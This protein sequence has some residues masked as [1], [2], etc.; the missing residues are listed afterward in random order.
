MAGQP[1]AAIQ[2]KFRALEQNEAQDIAGVQA[3]PGAHALLTRLDALRIPW[4]IVTSG[5]VPVPVP[6]ARARHTAAGLPQPAVFITAEQ[7]EKGKPEPDTYLLGAKKLGLTAESCV[8]VEDAPAG[9]LSGLNAR[10]AVIAVD[11]PAATPRRADTLMQLTTL[12]ALVVT[13]DAQGGFSL[14]QQA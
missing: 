10:C 9:I 11:A 7:V 12:D 2:A 8:M 5:S 6:V 3:L 14:S 1:E 4:A 13:P